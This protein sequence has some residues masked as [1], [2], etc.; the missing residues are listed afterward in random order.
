MDFSLDDIFFPSDQS[1]IAEQYNEVE[2]P[3]EAQ[4]QHNKPGVTNMPPRT[5]TSPMADLVATHEVPPG[6]AG[7]DWEASFRQARTAEV[8]ATAAGDARQGEARDFEFT[9]WGYSGGEVETTHVA[10][11]ASANSQAPVPTPMT[12]VDEFFIR[13]GACRPPTPCSHCR[14]RRLQCLILQTT[15]ANPNPTLSCSSCVALFRECSLSGRAKR[16]P[17]QFETPMPVIGHLHGVKEQ[18]SLAEWADEE[19]IP[20]QPMA[21]VPSLSALAGKRAN[22]R[23]VRKTRALKNW[24]STH[25]DYPYPSEEDKI[26]LSK[27]SGLSKNQVVNWFLNARRRHRHHAHLQNLNTNRV[28]VHGSPMPQH[29]NMSPMERWRNSPP[30]E[31]ATLDS[32]IETLLSAQYSSSQGS[33]DNSYDLPSFEDPEFWTSGDSLAYSDFNFDASSNSASS[34]PSHQSAVDPSIFSRSAG[35]AVADERTAPITTA[36]RRQSP[37]S[38]SKAR[39]TFQCTFCDQTYKKKYDWARH[40]R[41]V[42]LPGL[43]LWI[44]SWPV[45]LGQPHTIWPVGEGEARCVFCGAAS[46]TEEHIGSHEFDACAA[47]PVSERRFTR[48]DHLWQHLRKFHQCCRW[49]GWEPDLS[50]L[51]HRQDAV[52]SRCGFCP[53]TLDSWKDRVEHLAVHFRAGLTMDSWGISGCGVIDAEGGKSSVG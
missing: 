7:I 52:H 36:A 10:G 5:S 12:G 6:M 50:L 23:S 1:A 17:S 44:C 35:S 49:S 37:S 26:A 22:T 27:E 43:D 41:S 19:L 24:F 45:A 33:A 34:C 51:H 40:E 30:E 16:D 8:G 42:H 39:H 20:S 48:K 29:A 25:I 46:P 15:E 18:E 11:Q 2:I 4:P 14:R 53:A 47:R 9:L 13:N 3:V 32:A 28:F 31:E 21:R 38:P